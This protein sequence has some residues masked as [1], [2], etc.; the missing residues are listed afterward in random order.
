[1]TANRRLFSQEL[2]MIM[3][4]Q[5]YYPGKKSFGVNSL[6]KSQQTYPE[7]DS[8]HQNHVPCSPHSGIGPTVVR[9]RLH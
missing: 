6:G 7:N 3:L 5:T 8:R 2:K 1:M 4:P 9:L